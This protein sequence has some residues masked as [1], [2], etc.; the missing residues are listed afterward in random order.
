MY[1]LDFSNSR[2]LFFQGLG[3]DDDALL[4]ILSFRSKEELQA[5]QAEYYNSKE[6]DIENSQNVGENCSKLTKLGRLQ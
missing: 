6:N 3:T 4:E 1:L 2:I 5:I